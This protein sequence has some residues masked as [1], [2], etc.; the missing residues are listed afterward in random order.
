MFI[1]I[2][3]NR[4]VFMNYVI[5]NFT[6]LQNKLILRCSSLQNSRYKNEST[7]LNLGLFTRI[8]NWCRRKY[9]DRFQASFFVHQ[10]DL[11][12]IKFGARKMNLHAVG[13]SF[14]LRNGGPKSSELFLN[15]NGTHAN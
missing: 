7:V 15:L 10:L 8:Q 3:M 2:H 11:I 5:L 6:L 9:F 13:I 12:C 14:F 4:K 1:C